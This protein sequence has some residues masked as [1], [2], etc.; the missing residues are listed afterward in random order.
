MGIRK[1]RIEPQRFAVFGLRFREPAKLLENDTEIASE[2]WHLRRR[3][4]GAF[5]IVP[6]RLDLAAIDRDDAE[7]VPPLGKIRIVAH[8][9]RADRFSLRRFA[10]LV[11]LPRTGKVSLFLR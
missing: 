3:V 5:E 6:R 9:L 11:M 1:R 8:E 10:R 2:R 4:P 7:Q